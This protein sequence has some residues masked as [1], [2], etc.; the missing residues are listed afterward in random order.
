MRLRG[1]VRLIPPLP[2][3]LS[4]A[5][6]KPFRGEAANVTGLVSR[7]TV[8][9]VPPPSFIPLPLRC[10]LAAPSERDA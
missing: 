9:I 1:V 7:A 6:R 2:P 4:S 3:Y 8:S 5:A 10:G